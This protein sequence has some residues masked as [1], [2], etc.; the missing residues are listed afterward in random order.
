MF[1]NISKLEIKFHEHRLSPL[2][3][4]ERPRIRRKPFDKKNIYSP[5]TPS[6]EVELR[7]IHSHQTT[8]SKLEINFSMDFERYS[9]RP[10]HPLMGGPFK[11]GV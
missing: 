4:S 11:T 8:I 7:H 2:S 6:W 9:S 3:P 5:N 1:A 10:I